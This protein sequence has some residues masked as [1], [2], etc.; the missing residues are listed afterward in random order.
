MQNLVLAENNVNVRAEPYLI[1]SITQA[2][3]ATDLASFFA[4]SSVGDRDMVVFEDAGQH[5][6]D[7][8]AYQAA[9]EGVLAAVKAARPTLTLRVCTT[10]DNSPSAGLDYQW[11]VSFA[12][13]G[14]LNQATQAAAAAQSVTVIDMN[15][16]ITAY[17]A[18]AAL[19][20]LTLPNADNIHLNVWD[21]MKFAGAVLAS[22]G[23]TPAIVN[24]TSL[25]D[26]ASANYTS[27]AYG[28]VAW[29]Q[30][31]SID[32]CVAILG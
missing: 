29:T 11:D 32:Y 27:L 2:S 13:E 22:F 15:T 9:Y 8:S 12:G 10:A 3:L 28:S 30:Q 21:Q 20:G 5:N 19:D 16:I 31:K 1:G 17:W 18:T 26:I 23:L 14:T 6:G 4:S 25:T 7:P 24:R